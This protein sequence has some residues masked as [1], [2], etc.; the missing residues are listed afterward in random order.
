MK[1]VT[2][3]MLKPDAFASGKQDAI[4]HDMQA[5]G[6]TI[7]KSAVL[8]V[9]M[10]VMK[11][12]L[13]HYQSVIDAM[14]PAFDFPGK[15]FRSFYYYGP[16]TIMPMEVSC[17]GVEDIIEY[18]RALTGKTNPQEAGPHTLRGKYSDDSYERSSAENRLVCNVIHA[19]DSLASAQ[20]ELKIWSRYLK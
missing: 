14:E 7:E 3:M 6:L 8:T 20:K 10:E 19:S 17:E 16:H 11:T 18:T 2:F 15:L 5:H 13:E 9:D 4:L 12:L 1:Q